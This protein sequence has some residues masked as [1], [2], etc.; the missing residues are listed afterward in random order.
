VE[1]KNSLLQAL[2]RAFALCGLQECVF[3]VPFAYCISAGVRFLFAGGNFL[4]AASIFLF[5]GIGIL[6][7]F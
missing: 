1:T 4:F 5:V 2:P 7:S 3:C 6:S